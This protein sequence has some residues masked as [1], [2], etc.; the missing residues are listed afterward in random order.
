LK[1]FVVWGLK[2]FWFPILLLILAALGKRCTW[3]NE[4]HTKLKKFK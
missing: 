4:V 3:A 2:N 1:R